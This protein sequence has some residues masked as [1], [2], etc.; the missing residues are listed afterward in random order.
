RRNGNVRRAH[1]IEG[2]ELNFNVNLSLMIGEVV[3]TYDDAY[4]FPHIMFQVY[5]DIRYQLV[6]FRFLTTVP[7]VVVVFSWF[8]IVIVVH[9]ERVHQPLV[10]PVLLERAP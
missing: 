8:N 2:V 6:W 9:L 4:N 5:A 3:R 7:C 1:R 10:S